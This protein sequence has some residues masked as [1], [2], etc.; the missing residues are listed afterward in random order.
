M[1]CLHQQQQHDAKIANGASSESDS[2]EGGDG[3][4]GT[5]A[6]FT[7]PGYSTLG[8]SILS[9]SNCGNPGELQARAELRNSH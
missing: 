1:Y 6:L 5:P 3:I 4:K 7:D 9:T 2:D 8:E